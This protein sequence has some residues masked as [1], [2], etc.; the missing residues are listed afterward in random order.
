MRYPNLLLAVVV[1]LTAGGALRAANEPHADRPPEA[2]RTWT[3]DD[4]ERI[5]KIPGL[6]SIVGQLTSEGDRKRKCLRHS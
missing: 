2:N 6:I 5:S 3:N 1:S 4:L